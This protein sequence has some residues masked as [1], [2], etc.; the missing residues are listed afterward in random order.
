MDSRARQSAGP[1]FLFLSLILGGSAQGIWANMTLQLI[2]VATLAWSALDQSHRPVKAGARELL[3]LAI[4]AIALVAIQLM[5]LPASV[6]SG[7]GGRAAIADGYRILG[8][9]ISALPLSLTPQKSFDALL[10]IIP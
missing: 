8:L 1:L 9:G 3:V 10:A 6:W 5:P 2:G 4:L 7:L